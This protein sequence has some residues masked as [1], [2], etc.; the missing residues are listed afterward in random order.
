MRL[1]RWEISSTKPMDTMAP[2]N[3]AAMR[4]AEEVVLPRLRSASMATHTVIFAP[5]EIPST[6]GPAMGLWKKVCSR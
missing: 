4:M 6:K 2:T 1:T 3:A 5:E